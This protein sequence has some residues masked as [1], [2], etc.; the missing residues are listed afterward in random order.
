MPVTK[1]TKPDDVK[2]L[3]WAGNYAADAHRFDLVND[4]IRQE[5]DLLKR[6]QA[7]VYASIYGMGAYCEVDPNYDPQE[8]LRDTDRDDNIIDQLLERG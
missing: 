7:D 2:N 3:G 1:V 5:P 4:Y 6:Q 8:A